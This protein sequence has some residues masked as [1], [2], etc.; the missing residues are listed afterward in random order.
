MRWLSRLRGH[1]SRQIDEQAEQL[2][3]RLIEVD[4]E[5]EEQKQVERDT[6]ADRLKYLEAQAEVMARRHLPNF[7]G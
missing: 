5:R 4:T 7:R 1:R 2:R 3:R 6:I